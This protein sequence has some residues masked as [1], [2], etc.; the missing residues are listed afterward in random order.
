MTWMNVTRGFKVLALLLFLA[1]WLL[2]SCQGSPLIEASGLQ[3]ITG[4]LEPSQD[5]PMGAMMAQAQL[6][7]GTTAQAEAEQPG[8][9]SLENGRWWALAGAV[10]IAASLAL[11]LAL[12]PARMA[13]FSATV[14]AALALLILGGGMAW[15]VQ[16][17]KSELRE[18][19]AQAPAGDDEFSQFG[20]TMAAGV[21]GGIAIDVRWGFWMTELALLLAVVSGGLAV[22]GQG[23]PTVRVSVE[24]PGTD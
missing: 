12:R 19:A 14:A 3:L 7:E 6:E 22:A 2:V 11:G 8:T 23:I 24:P 17:F 9:A 16:S 10:L 13:A 4:D 21:V 15:T 18:A 20:R 1:P 5:S